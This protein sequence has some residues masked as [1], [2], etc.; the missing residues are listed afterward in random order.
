MGSLAGHNLGPYRVLE[1]IGAGGMATVYKAYHAAMD[2]YVAI[3]VLPQHLARDANFR[4][5]FQREARTIARLEHRY[6]LPVHDVREDDDIPYIVMRYTGGGDLGE[7]IASRSLSIARAA[8]LVTQ[9]AEALAY[10]HHQGIIHRD[11]KPANVLLSRDGDAL[12]TDFGIAKIYEDTLQLTGDGVMVGT[13]MY[14]APEQLQGQPVDVRTDIYALGVVLYQ[15]LTYEPPFVAETPLAVALM[16]IHNPLRPPR[17]L[18]SKIPE[19]LER[20]VLRA[21]AKDANDR[22]QTADEMAQAL[23]AAMAG[24]NS[25]TAVMTTE[26]ERPPPA[27][28]PV[29]PAVAPRR[30]RWVW[31]AAGGVVA[32]AVLAL[33][34][35]GA[36]LRPSG[37][38]T[39]PSS[40]AG[41]PGA[42]VAPATAVA[43]GA[44]PPQGPTVPPRAN[45]STFTNSVYVNSLAV[46]GDTVWAGTSGGLARYSADGKRRLFTVVDGLPFNRVVTVF[47]APDGTLWLG[48]YSQIAHVRPVADGLGDVKVYDDNLDVGRI[49][50]FMIDSDQS[51]WVGGNYNGVRRFDGQKWTK[52][53]LP[54][55]DP[56][57]KDI[58]PDVRALLRSSDGALWLGLTDALVR[59]DGKR[60][61]VFSDAQGVGK[62]YISRLLQDT[63]GTI[64]AAADKGLLRYDA[65]QDRWQRQQVSVLPDDAP[66]YAIMQL[67][68]GGLWASSD[69]LI[70]RSADGGKT[71]ERAASSEDGI[72]GSIWTIVQDAAGQVW[73]GSNE[74]INLFAAGQWR[75]LRPQGELPIT[76]IGSLTAA[77]D[78]KL[79]AIE[80]YGGRLGVIDPASM[81]IEQPEIPDDSISSVA[82]T[83]KDT[84]WLG[85]KGKGVV[86]LLGG[87]TKRL[88]SANGLPSDEI[89]AL[90]ATDTSLWIG[91]DKGLAF[92]DFATEKVSTVTEFNDGIVDSLLRAPNGDI[93]AGSIIENGAGMLALGRY[94]GKAWQMW[95]KGDQPL[96]E[97]SSGVVALAA[98]TQGHIW[99]SVWN[100]G[101]YSWDGATWKSWTKDDG[102]PD[103]NALV[104]TPHND[105]LWVGGQE[106]NLAGKVYRWSKEGWKPF[107]IDGLA[108]GLSDMRFTADG[109]LWLATDD[110]VLRISKEGVA[111]LR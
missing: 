13:P 96:P 53:D 72:S 24:L 80:K 28:P 81:R 49:Q 12:L 90:L 10:A 6:I 82:F 77:P 25:Q 97:Q 110:G 4:A 3:K 102:A 65:A 74:G 31:L 46:L 98:D 47:A 16:H 54:V 44:A 37:I 18:N 14:M 57:V 22:F 40:N 1:Q 33:A 78:G 27:P 64:W 109:A 85:T 55:D 95:R 91:T 75:Q 9:V 94:D 7:L 35:L 62:A 20:I 68:D 19:S 69:S 8:Q 107:K 108:G 104:L 29:P 32:G 5:R 111:A 101:I 84:I 30:P 63:N 41:T 87:A 21:M 59:L 56:V 50:S 86:R 52:P 88:T 92:Y 83:A 26:E 34:L 23:R 99:V 100:G 15:A 89:R 103:G 2:R 48:S 39:A 71:W 70:A 73:A 36:N 61:T 58:Q 51:I 76:E 38:G 105:D 93:W 17:Q 66:I 60:W 43:N 106:G 67:G 45:L 79:W 42:L 11:V